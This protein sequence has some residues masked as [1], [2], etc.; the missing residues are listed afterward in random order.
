MDYH[1]L[2]EL[3]PMLG[4]YQTTKPKHEQSVPDFLV[5]AQTH[6]AI[7]VP[8]MRGDQDRLRNDGITMATLPPTGVSLSSTNDTDQ[9]GLGQPE[10]DDPITIAN[11]YVTDTPT[12]Y[13]G[14][15]DA[16]SAI[17]R[18]VI[19]LGRYAKRYSKLAL[20]DSPFTSLDEVTFLASIIEKPGMSKMEVILRNTQEKPQGMEVI[21]RLTAQGLIEIAK[22][23]DKKRKQPLQ[24]TAEGQLAFFGFIPTMGQIARL[25]VGNLNQAEQD[26]LFALLDKLDA[27]HHPYYANRQH[28]TFDEL[29]AHA[30]RSVG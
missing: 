26:Q 8:Q 29:L 20:T 30:L 24:A 28:N 25:V 27:F 3:L 21:K 22:S 17:G 10:T 19:V 12:Q 5:W 2:T 13:G 23:E 11:R 18:L 16:A 9:E 4:Q 15:P 1:L 7:R 14:M 6:A